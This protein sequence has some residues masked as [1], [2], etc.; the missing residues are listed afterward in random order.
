VSSR[1]SPRGEGDGVGPALAGAAVDDRTSWEAEAQQ[2]RDLVEG[3]A[4]GV[5][6][7]GA[8]RLHRAGDVLDQQQAGVAARHQHRDRRLGQRA[9]LEDVDG[10]VRGQVVDAVQRH[11]QGQRVGLGGRDAD[12]QR[13]GRGRA[14][15]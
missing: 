1:S 11:A 5:V 12:Q 7:G 8:E 4:G 9:V 14:R 3:F 13:A 6:D 10:H 15:R 2:P